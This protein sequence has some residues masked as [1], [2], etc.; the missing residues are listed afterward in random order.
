MRVEIT[1]L[2][3]DSLSIRAIAPVNESTVWFAANQGVVGLLNN[4]DKKIA[5]IKYDDKPLHFRAISSTSQAVFVLSI[6]NPAVLYKIGYSGNEAT[7]IE[8]VYTEKGE[9][10]FYDALAFWDDKEGIAMGDPVENCLSVII[11]RDGGNSWEKVPCNLLPSI[12]NGE[13]A[14]AASNT[15]IKVLGNKVWIATGGKKA[16]VFYSADRGNTWEVFKTPIIQG[17]AMTGIYS[18]DFY[19]KNIGMIVGGDWENKDFNEGNKALTINGGKTWK[20]VANG[21]LPGYLSCVQFVP[22]SNGNSLVGVSILG[23]FYSNNRG[24]DWKQLSNDGFY[25]VRFV[26]D[27]LAFASGKN[28]LSR[29]VFKEK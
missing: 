11:T 12:E 26:N 10:V 25:S 20:L 6:D 27:S 13:A 15:S 3:Q 24:E 4:E 23:V 7:H 21:K 18:I 16:R 17:M 14:F 9:K 19:D 28:K 29:L 5:V 22:N 8:E 1:P 2:L